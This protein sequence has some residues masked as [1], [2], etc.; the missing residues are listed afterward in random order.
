VEDLGIPELTDKQMEELCTMAE[1]AAR[2]YVL[3]KLP[4]K[5]IKMLNVSAE[6]EGTKPL[7]LAVDVDITLTKLMKDYNAKNLVNEAVKEAFRAAEKYLRELKC[8]LQK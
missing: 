8:H 6:A 4:S 3:S 7:T 5:G 1:E 2:R